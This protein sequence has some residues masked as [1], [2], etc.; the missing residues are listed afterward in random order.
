MQL[1]L[2][3][4]LAGLAFAGIS[5]AL[6]AEDYNFLNVLSKRVLTP[7]N[8]CGNAANGNGKNYTCDPTLANGGG[9]CSSSGY[10]GLSFTQYMDI[11]RLITCLR[12]IKCILWVG[13]PACLRYLLWIRI[14]SNRP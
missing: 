3:Q 5:I 6:P 10:C 4:V 8:T 12:H 2:V 13:L 14:D 9:C 11:H 1:K 7:D